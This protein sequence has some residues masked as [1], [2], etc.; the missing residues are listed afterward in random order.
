MNVISIITKV[1]SI[2]F[3]FFHRE[4]LV[5]AFLN[6]LKDLFYLDLN[7][8]VFRIVLLKWKSRNLV[9]YILATKQFCGEATKSI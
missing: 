9:Q 7:Y 1:M 5:I 4:T 6:K 2:R 3:K 8:S